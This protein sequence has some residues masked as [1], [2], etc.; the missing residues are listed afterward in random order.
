MNISE[1]SLDSIEID[2]SVHFSYSQWARFNDSLDYA[3]CKVVMASQQYFM[4]VKFC[5]LD[6]GSAAL[7]YYRDEPSNSFPF[8]CQLWLITSVRAPHHT[9]RLSTRTMS[10]GRFRTEKLQYGLQ[11]SERILEE[12]HESFIKL[13]HS[14]QDIKGSWSLN[15]ISRSHDIPSDW[16]TFP[17]YVM[18]Q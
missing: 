14:C 11:Y 9:S 12:C 7:S 13:N 17:S 18:F 6:N 3:W 16:L 15:W 5:I 1:H 4:Q 8:K 2:C 10:T